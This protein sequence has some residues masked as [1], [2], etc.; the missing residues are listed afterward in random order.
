M[1][2]SPHEDLHSAVGG[3]FICLMFALPVGMLMWALLVVLIW[4]GIAK[5]LQ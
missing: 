4:S 3:F 2:S 1:S 5:V